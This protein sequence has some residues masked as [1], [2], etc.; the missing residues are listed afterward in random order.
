MTQIADPRTA[1][2]G[3]DSVPSE[4]PTGEA[5]QSSHP[6]ARRSAADPTIC[7]LLD[8]ALP[9]GYATE[10]TGVW[11]S[12][13][14]PDRASNQIQQGWKLHVSARPELL[15][16]TLDQVL[17][18]LLKAGCDFKVIASP[19]ILRHFNAGLY[20]AGAMGKALT[21]YPSQDRVVDLALQLADVLRGFEGPQINSDRRVRPDAP[22]YYRFG[23]FS[24][25][26]RIDDAGQMDIMLRAPD[27]RLTSGIAGETYLSPGWVE[28]PFRIAGRRDTPLPRIDGSAVIGDHYKIVSA[29][30]R[31]YRGASY[32]AIDLRSGDRVIVKESKAFVNETQ[33]GDA[34]EYLRN[35][36]RVLAALEG[37]PDVPLVIDHFAYGNDEFL[38]TT[39]L[40]SSNLRDDIVDSGVFAFEPDTPRNVFDLGR[41]LLR[42]LD[43]V[44]QRGVIYRDLAPKNVVTL[45]DGGWGFV[46]FELSRLSG[47]QRYGWSAGY[48]HI[49]QRRDESGGIADDYFSLGATLFHAVTGLDPIVIEESHESNVAR[50][51]GCL[52]TICGVSSPIVSLIGDLLDSGKGIQANAIHQL[53]TGAFPKGRSQATFGPPDLP[54]ELVF[55]HTLDV[56]LRHARTILTED[57]RSRPLPPPVTAYGGIAGIMMELAHHPGALDAAIEL[58]RMTAFI[59]E[60]VDTP[61]AL[62]YGR[63]GISLAIQAVANASGDAD[64]HRVAD[65]IM[66]GKDD[67]SIEQRV[68]VTHGL[69][70]LGI[71]FLAF[72]ETASNSGPYWTLA[73]QCAERLLR[74]ESIIDE[75][76][77]ALPVGNVA[78]GISVADGFAHGRAGIA[79]FLL[80]YAAQTGHEES[81]R[82]ARKLIDALADLVPDLAA[83]AESRLARPMAAS[84]CQGLAG[85]G[86][87]LVRSARFFEDERL[88]EASQTAAAGCLAVAS[89][90]PLVTQCC[91]MAGIGEFLLDLAVVTNDTRFRQDAMNILDLMLTRSGGSRT[92]PS[93][94]DTSLAASTPAWA[95]GAS[96]VLSYLRRLINPSSPRLWMADRTVLRG[97]RMAG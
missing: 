56:V 87:T 49:R 89:R 29:I 26:L 73:G 53:R 43:A 18:V 65:A 54:L 58:A 20:G 40:G 90:V 67:I 88:L 94:P 92:A 23:P 86:T 13:M 8:R 79:C 76:L 21:I 41:T 7:A 64:L 61:P 52:A 11:V 3:F 36:R 78:H 37:I 91:G 96:G 45:A 15:A 25:H 22:V 16:A 63:M 71:G 32:R 50:T 93:F 48:S 82:Q 46:D 77:R 12:V 44:H 69:A 1:T 42:I 33:N 38:V 17:P 10:Q 4:A 75:Q 14:A 62:M 84:W 39:E 59:V 81:R 19:E 9:R 70:G 27:G 83:R 47:V 97:A 60:R 2:P 68:D 66:P 80:A 55:R 5:E 57:V 31:T 28:D 72:A 85:I 51:V 34:R 74:G 95:T 35:E 30:M 6:P 24:P